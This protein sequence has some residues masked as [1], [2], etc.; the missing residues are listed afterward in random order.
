MRDLLAAMG[1]SKSSF[2]H[3]FESKH[4]L[5]QRCLQHYHEMLLGDLRRSLAQANPEGQFISTLLSSVSCECEHR[6]GCLIMNTASEFAQDDPLIAELVATSVEQF[7]EFFEGVILRAQKRGE[8]TREHDAQAL[9]RY[10]L[11]SLSGL[12]SMVKAGV[13]RRSIDSVAQLVWRAL[14]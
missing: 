1:I 6:R 12:R 2:Y 11:S 10:L 13:D 5:F 4:L 14:V 9:A 3:V 8:I 7:V